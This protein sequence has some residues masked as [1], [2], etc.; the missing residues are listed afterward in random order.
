MRKGCVEEY[1]CIVTSLFPMGCT[2]AKLITG[3]EVRIEHVQGPLGSRRYF[4][5]PRCSSRRE[6]LYLKD[7]EV[8]CRKCHSLNYRSSQQN[9][10][11][12]SVVWLRATRSGRKLGVE[13]KPPYFDEGVCKPKG[14][15]WATYELLMGELRWCSIKWAEIWLSDVART[16]F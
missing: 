12:Y 2:E 16:R 10:N 1:G 5:C 14:M 11:R 3:Q 8:A 7:S 9:H 4:R 6:K 15:R 13:V